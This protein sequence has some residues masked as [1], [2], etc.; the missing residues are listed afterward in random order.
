[1]AYATAEDLITRYGATE[2]ARLSAADGAS[3]VAV[4][5]ARCALALDDATALIESYLR[6]RYQLPLDPVPREIL[7]AACALAR[8]G[9]A[10]GGGRE[11]SDQI[12]AAR[13]ETIA[14]LK[15]LASGAAQI[16]G[17]RPIGEGREGARTADRD[18]P[19]PTGSIPGYV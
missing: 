17:A 7:A 6:A 2:I 3:V 9:L 15:Q 5:P 18:R 12:K 4:D 8:H 13:D 1:M 10:Q 11:P 14:W 19:L 16:A